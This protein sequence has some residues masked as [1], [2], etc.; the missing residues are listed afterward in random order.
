MSKKTPIVFHNRSNYNYRFCKKEL[1]EQF[2]KQFTCL[3]ENIEKYITFT[4][5]VEKEVTRID[6]NGKEIRKDIFYIS[7]FIDGTR[8]MARLLSNVVNNLLMEFIELNVNLDMMTKNVKHVNLNISIA[9]VFSNTQILKI[10]I[11]TS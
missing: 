3:D 10:I 1:A 9:T 2:K 7:Q 5:P 8:F 6:K 11:N 4:V